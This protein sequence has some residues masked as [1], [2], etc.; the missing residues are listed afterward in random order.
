MSQR[1]CNHLTAGQL[2]SAVVH[3]TRRVG[4]PGHGPVWV[5]LCVSHQHASDTELEVLARAKLLRQQAPRP[6]N[7]AKIV[8]G[9]PVQCKATLAIATVRLVTDRNVRIVYQNGSTVG[10]SRRQLQRYYQ[11]PQQQTT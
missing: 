5:C 9:M 4:L 6:I 7:P 11:T 8:P 1:S 10:M 2:C 3:T